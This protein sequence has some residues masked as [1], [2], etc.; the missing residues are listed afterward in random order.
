MEESFMGSI[1]PEEE[2]PTILSKNIK[3]G[4]KKKEDVTDTDMSVY[5]NHIKKL[6]GFKPNAYKPDPDEPYFTLGYG[7]YGK[8]IK[9]GM[10]ITKEEAE[11][12]LK[13]DIEDRLIQ[14][15]RFIPNFKNMPID[16]KKHML[17]SWF[18]GGLSGSSNTIKL[19]NEGKF[20]EASVEFLNHAEYRNTKLA[21]VKTRMKNTSEAIA[22]ME[23]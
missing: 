20:K 23:K 22:R 13:N 16:A 2:G 10:T 12:N 15:E 5:V 6:E 1:I 3:M 18:R 14:I 19:I 4:T 7:R 17:D 11:K 9:E 21:G 8:N